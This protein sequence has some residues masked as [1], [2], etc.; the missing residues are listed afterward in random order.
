MV[1]LKIPMRIINRHC[2][3]ELVDT[4]KQYIGFV[5][6]RKM[7]SRNIRTPLDVAC[8]AVVNTN[9]VLQKLIPGGT[10]STYAYGGGGLVQ[11]IFRQ[12]KISLQLHCNPKI[13]AHFTL[14][15]MHMNRKHP[16]TMQRAVR[17]ALAKT[18]ISVKR[19]LMFDV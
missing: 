8:I 3:C 14:R 13:S 5:E 10:L 1:S 2:S 9:S 18:E 17:V 4:A 11:E 12:A 6:C 7:C 19:C 16:E 15:N